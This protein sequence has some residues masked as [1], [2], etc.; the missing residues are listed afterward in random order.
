VRLAGV[1][2][3]S[4]QVQTDGE[5]PGGP[6]R[7]VSVEP[8][9]PQ[10]L[11]IT[12][13][14]PDRSLWNGELL[15]Y[16]IGY[17][18]LGYR[19]PCL[20]ALE[21]RA[22]ADDARP[23]SARVPCDNDRDD[24]VSESG[25]ADLRA[26]ASEFTRSERRDTRAKFTL[27]TAVSFTAGPPGAKIN[28]SRRS[29]TISP[30][31]IPFPDINASVFLSCFAPTNFSNWHTRTWDRALP[32]YRGMV[33]MSSGDMTELIELCADGLKCLRCEISERNNRIIL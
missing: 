16:N 26:S 5:V 9:G 28:E 19:Y 3:F 29:L 32:L 31:A 24:R 25:R 12:W 22:S 20:P 14:P 15:G 8:L 2:E 6:P 30:F 18:N 17:T 23:S 27:A 33:L 21:P 7:H 1:S 11:K 4:E 13:Q 10:Q